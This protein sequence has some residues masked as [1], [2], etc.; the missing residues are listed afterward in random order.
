MHVKNILLPVRAL[1][2]SCALLVLAAAPL[3]AGTPTQA[4]AALRVW[5]SGPSSGPAPGTIIRLLQSDD[6]GGEREQPAG[7]DG[8]AWFGALIPGGY[9]VLV[10]APGAEAVRTTVEVGPVETVTLRV[11]LAASGQGTSRITAVDRHRQGQGQDFSRRALSDLPGA[12]DLWA[13]LE[14]AAPF[15]IADRT[16]TGGLGTGASA[17]V[18]TRGESWALTTLAMGDLRVTHPGATGRLAFAPDMEAVQTV[19]V[20]SGLSPVDLATPGVYITLVPKRA[21]DRWRGSV[22]AAATSA[23]M[24]GT[25]ALPLAPSVARLESYRGTSV[26]GGGPLGPHSGLFLTVSRSAARLKERDGLAVLPAEQTTVSAHLTTRP[27]DAQEV[28]LL[29]SIQRVRYPFDDRRQ[30]ANPA[31][32]ARGTFGQAQ[33]TWERFGTSGARRHLSFGAER[34][35]SRPDIAVDATGGVIDRVRDGIVPTSPMS[36]TGSA[37]SVRGVLEPAVRR[38]AGV[39]HA[40]KA[41]LTF[42]RAEET[43]SVLALPRVAESVNGL[44]ARIWSP[45]APE[46]TARRRLTELGLYVGDRA[47]LGASV[48]V[49]LGA[50][51]DLVDGLARGAAQGLDWTIVSPRVAFRWS[52]RRVSVF[53]GYGRSLAADPMALLSYGDPGMPWFQVRRWTDANASGQFEP[54]EAG[55]LVA[56]QGRHAGLASIASSLRAPVSDEWTL[57]LDYRFTPSSILRGTMVVRRQQDLVG[58]INTGVPLSA[59]RV[60]TIPDVGS[61]EG[62]PQDDQILSIYER[63]PASF[64]QDQFLLANPDGARVEYDGIEITY[65]LTSSR[66]WMLFGATAYRALGSGGHLGAGPLENDPL[67][68]GVRYEQPNAAFNEPGRLFGDRA[69]VGKWSG[70]YRAPGDVRLAATVRYQDGQPFTRMVI[71]RDHAGG[72]EMI[73]AYPLGKTR[74]TY[75]GTIDARIE[76]GFA[77]GARRLAVRLDLFNLSNHRNE[78]DED[79]VG[80]PA[81][82]RSTLVQPPRTIRLGV[83]VDF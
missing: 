79:V 39:T 52:P 60:Y 17:L 70:T 81:F 3:M 77:L 43:S 20:T 29:A 57:G 9:D 66:W 13:L 37:W 53:G 71:A 42:R 27:S 75:T 26:S 23:G 47:T 44:P 16:D 33:L 80:G 68:I 73:Q 40:L 72:P 83:R 32:D 58:S 36:V 30:F 11:T 45:V 2:L 24:V 64:G 69:Y 54:G 51:V 62:G 49:D 38:V 19:S 82:R 12:A 28:R 55:V 5:V 61:D 21:S 50:R 46:V 18:S 56:R 78:V 10:E 15:V 67:V 25:N 65:E 4:V 14:T 31:V 48:T 8:S 1:L 35:Q 6:A 22:D 34:G 41:G 7:P 74:F 59:Y 76:K 63:L